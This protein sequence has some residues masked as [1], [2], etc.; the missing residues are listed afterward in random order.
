MKGY[1]VGMPAYCFERDLPPG[2]WTDDTAM[3]L[4]EMERIAQDFSNMI[5][6]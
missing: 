6:S 4:A 5:N 1:R 2:S 3:V